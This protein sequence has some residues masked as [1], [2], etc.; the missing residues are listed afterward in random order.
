MV[1]V[2]LYLVS[3]DETRSQMINA[4][5]FKQINSYTLIIPSLLYVGYRFICLIL[6]FK[7]I[8]VRENEIEIPVFGVFFRKMIL[9]K[10]QIKN[11]QRF[12]GPIPLLILDIGKER[13]ALKVKYF[14]ELQL[15][16]FISSLKV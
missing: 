5:S 10:S 8:T 11:V 6:F 14:N 13:I 9:K 2:V 7:F 1:M 3:I 15:E 16:E 4:L 12:S